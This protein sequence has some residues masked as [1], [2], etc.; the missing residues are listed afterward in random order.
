MSKARALQRMRPTIWRTL[1][2]TCAAY[3]LDVV[4]D[5]ACL[6]PG[7]DQ[8]EAAVKAYQ[9]SAAT[10]YPWVGPDD[11]WPGLATMCALWND[12]RPDAA[13]VVARA[14]A[15]ADGHAITYAMGTSGPEWMADVFDAAGDGADCSD[16]VSYVL[17]RRKA[18]GPDWTT[19]NGTWRWLHTSAVWADAKGEQ[20]LFRAIPSPVGPCIAVYPDAG[21]HQ[22]HIGLVVSVTGEV[23][24]GVDCSSS[25]SRKYHDAV[26]LRDLSFF[27]RKDAALFCQPV[28]W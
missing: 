5:P 22:G 16:L 14:I 13:M 1:T 15:A 23:L 19:A 26:A 9:R 8:R 4:S 17:G 24:R 25:Q 2:R 7:I 20:R 11:G 21:G 6:V 18:G 10:R 12:N 3:G 27:L 28:W